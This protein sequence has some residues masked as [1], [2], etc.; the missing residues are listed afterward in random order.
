MLV[1]SRV[2][3]RSAGVS[4]TTAAP[5]AATTTTGSLTTTTSAATALTTTS[6]SSTSPSASVSTRSSASATSE[7]GATDKVYYLSDQTAVASDAVYRSAVTR[8]NG[9]PHVHTVVMFPSSQ[10]TVYI[11]Y[12]LSRRC[13]DFAFDAG[14]TDES[15][16]ASTAKFEVSDA[17]ANTQF[18][19][20]QLRFGQDHKNTVSVRD[21]LRLKLTVTS[22]DGGNVAAAWG[23]ARITCAA[24]PNAG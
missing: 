11:E 14:F 24:P 5:P 1:S 9:V 6:G 18:D 7:S 3:I 20:F 4:P 21:V 8:I 15:D 12:N 19:S 22:I 16:T 2:A 10:S 17:V 23:D 13:A